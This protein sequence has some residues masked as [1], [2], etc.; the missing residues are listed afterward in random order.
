MP[1]ER[2][3][4]TPVAR[5]VAVVATCIAAGMVG[6]PIAAIA[7]PA[8]TDRPFTLQARQAVEHDDNLLRLADGE[9]VPAG[10]SRT[11]TRAIGTLGG[12]LAARLGRQTARAALEL[13]DHRHADNPGFDHVAHRASFGLDVETAGRL[14]GTLRLDHAGGIVAFEDLD[15]LDDRG[16][17]VAGQRVRQRTE[18]AGL[19]LR[20][21]A[22]LGLELGL[23]ARR[24]RW[25][26]A[27][28]GRWQVA[29]RQL[30]TGVRWTPH[31]QAHVALQ[32]RA[33]SGR[34]SDAPLPP[35]PEA[36]RFTLHAVELDARWPAGAWTLEAALGHERLRLAG[37]LAGLVAGPAA[38]PAASPLAGPTVDGA[39]RTDGGPTAR[40]GLR[41]DGGG[42]V[43]LG[44]ALERDHGLRSLDAAGAGPAVLRDTSRVEHALRARLELA[45]SAKLGLDATLRLAAV[46]L[47]RDS[48]AARGRERTVRLGLGLRWQ[49]LRSVDTRCE[50]VRERR[51]GA[52]ELGSSLGATRLGCSLGLTLS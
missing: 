20:R 2:P 46:D 32:V 36:P 44:L 26:G 15:D 37:P 10:L 38:S 9:P 8:D 12:S 1:T 42:A 30:G 17:I 25:D 28:L 7:Q 35:T 13:A 22:A 49:P 48:D 51:R 52:G 16:A 29:Q 23:H 40:F 39:R 24:T 5:A 14:D 31:E 19:T 6:G 33:G 43:R 11:D 50:A 21:G 27:G 41:R 4:R 18:R 34:G 45:P 47:E 3:V